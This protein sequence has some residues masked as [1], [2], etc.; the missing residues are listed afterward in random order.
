MHY[1]SEV[2]KFQGQTSYR[3]V[4]GTV[5]SKIMESSEGK[6]VFIIHSLSKSERDYGLL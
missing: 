6:N 4:I 1:Y 3:K 2:F 5:A